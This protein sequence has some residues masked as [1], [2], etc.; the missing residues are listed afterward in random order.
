MHIVS[1]MPTAGRLDGQAGSQAVRQAVRQAARQ[2]GRQSGMQA[3]QIK[4]KQGKARQGK[5]KQIKTGQAGRSKCKH[6]SAERCFFGVFWSALNQ[7][8][9]CG[10]IAT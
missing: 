4:A 3:R 7:A 1:W 5:A 10:P 9:Q 2:P 8:V 6:G